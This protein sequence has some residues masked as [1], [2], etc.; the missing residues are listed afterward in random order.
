MYTTANCNHS[1]Q[2]KLINALSKNQQRVDPNNLEHE[3]KSES[4]NKS[5]NFINQSN[6]HIHAYLQ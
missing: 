2:G 1:S 4:L 5:H 3:K 6:K